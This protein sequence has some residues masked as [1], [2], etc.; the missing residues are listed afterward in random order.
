M[1]ARAVEQKAQYRPP[2]TGPSTDFGAL[3]D[4]LH[5]HHIDEQLVGVCGEIE[6]KR[7]LLARTGTGKRKPEGNQR[8]D[9]PED[10][11]LEQGECG[12]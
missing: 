7:V 2:Q 9:S 10:I 3:S 5:R 8:D 1:V 6:L 11:P 12:G 4:P